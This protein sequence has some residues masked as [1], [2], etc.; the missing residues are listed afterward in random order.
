MEAEPYNQ[1]YFFFELIA[2][3]HNY[4]SLYKCERQAYAS[5]FFHLFWIR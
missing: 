1:S 2:Y 5:P 4:H 3:T